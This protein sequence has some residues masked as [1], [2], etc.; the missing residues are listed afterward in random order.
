MLV[1]GPLNSIMGQAESLL[2]I[3]NSQDYS[4]D[5]KVVCSKDKFR[6]ISKDQFYAC[7][8]IPPCSLVSVPF[9]TERALDIFIRVASS[10]HKHSDDLIDV[11]VRTY[12]VVF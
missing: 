12:I 8:N 7:S 3:V 5:I 10:D 9:V 6:Y 4:D 2:H 11:E 1:V